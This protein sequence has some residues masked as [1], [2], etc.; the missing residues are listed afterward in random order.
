M[1]YSQQKIRM[2]NKMQQNKF[3]KFYNKYNLRS[4]GIVFAFI[5]LFTTFSLIS[6]AFLSL[7]N[8]HN[9]IDQTAEIGIIACAMTVVIIGGGLDLS[10]G[11][12]FA[13]SGVTASIF[14]RMGYPELGFALALLTGLFL[15]LLNGLIINS[16]GMNPFIATLSTSYAIRGVALVLTGGFL[17]MVKDPSFTI[18]GQDYFLSIKYP[19][20]IFLVSAIIF[21][22]ILNFTKFGRQVFAIGGSTEASRLS[23]VRVGMISTITFCLTGLSAGLAAIITVSRIAQ[24]QS[25]LG[26]GLE[27][28]AIAAT[29]IGGTSILGGQGD[30]WRTVLGVLMLRMINNGFNILNVPPF[31]QRVISGL[32]I[33]FAVTLDILSKRNE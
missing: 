33:L 31:Y 22:I 1:Q 16:T 6:P 28:D 19:V 9:I 5:L 11:A 15:G 20:Y 7:R 12:I 25:D 14:G 26:G 10:V 13:V 27:L 29:V 17:I 3:S 24:G 21:S 30:I 23:G 8:L 2:G 4:Y 32:I 18:I